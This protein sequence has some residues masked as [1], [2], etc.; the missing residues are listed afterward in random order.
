[1]DDLNKASLRRLV[2]VLQQFREI[3]ST[4]PAHLIE[5]LMR[6]AID[7]GKNVKTYARE[8]GVST[9]TMSRHLLDLGSEFRS[10]E[11]GL[12]LIEKRISSRSL[13]EQEVYLTFKGRQI[14]EEVA[15]KLQP[16]LVRE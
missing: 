12:G 7:E 9:S 5:A 10:G 2:R 3:R 15:S 11:P 4:I 1:M 16:E 13:R 6:V 8:S 14:A